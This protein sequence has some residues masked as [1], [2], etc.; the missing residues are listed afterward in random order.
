MSWFGYSKAASGSNYR[1]KLRRKADCDKDTGRVSAKARAA[2]NLLVDSTTTGQNGYFISTA[3]DPCSCG[4]IPIVTSG[5]WAGQGNGSQGI[6]WNTSSGSLVVNLCKFGFWLSFLLESYFST[7][8]NM[9]KPLA[10]IKKKQN[11]ANQGMKDHIKGWEV[12]LL[13]FQ[14]VAKV[15]KT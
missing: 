10:S 15:I 3:S 7:S 13:N 11:R 6:P 12:A 14:M 5:T 4:K 8:Y 1:A 9:R 2:A